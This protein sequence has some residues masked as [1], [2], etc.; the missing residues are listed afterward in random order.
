MARQ[1]KTVHA[2]KTDDMTLTINAPKGR[3][4][5]P[6]PGCKHKDKRRKNRGTERQLLRK[7]DGG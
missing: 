5:M 2:R 4:V 7:N 6:P 3:G 1:M